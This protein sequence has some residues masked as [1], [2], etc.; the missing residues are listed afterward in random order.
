MAITIK[1]QDK[2][3]QV[4]P[5]ANQ[6][7]Q[8]GT[9]FTSVQR[10][11]QANQGNRLNQTVGTGVQQAGQ[12]TKQAVTGAQQQFQQQAKQTGLTSDQDVNATQQGIQQVLADP[13]KADDNTVQK[14]AQY[15]SGQ[16]GGPT[17]L[18]N[19]EQ[20]QQ[21]ATQAQ[22]LGQN[23][24][25]SGGRTALLQ[26]FVA[27]PAQ[28]YTSGQ[29]RL[30]LALMGQGPQQQLTQAQRATAGLGSQLDTAQQA[31]QAQ[32]QEYQARA[33][34]LKKFTEGKIGEQINPL[35]G[36]LEF[37]A[38]KENKRL[39]DVIG[40]IKSGTATEEDLKSAGLSDLSGGETFGVDLGSYVGLANPQGAASR[41]NIA[42]DQQR[43]R[44]AA[45]GKL[46]GMQDLSK[47][48]GETQTYDPSKQFV[49]TDTAKKAIQQSAADYQNE[50]AN[51]M[52]QTKDAEKD[53]NYGGF[54]PDMG[55]VEASIAREKA[56]EALKQKYKI[57]T[58]L[59]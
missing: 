41:S 49:G 45:L 52:A 7:R 56:L 47:E 42:S 58:K 26:R 32:A 11:A 33:E 28:T 39:A 31:A 3:K 57:G 59:A 9:G 37:K 22:Q 25:S 40:R 24:A 15:R 38:S 30:D 16:Y 5:A 55:A 46:G 51:I 29:S 14:F 36:E 54:A 44:L 13:T 27:K 34:G 53:P 10:V 8:V 21:Q 4:Q 19:A 12:Q 43:A 48:F 20:L 1:D 23:L 35:T 6:P 50:L 2:N 17:N 18:A